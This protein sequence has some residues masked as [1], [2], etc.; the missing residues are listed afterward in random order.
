MV[1]NRGNI[2]ILYGQDIFKAPLYP[3]RCWIPGSV[4]LWWSHETVRA[5]P[6]RRNAGSPSESPQYTGT[7]IGGQGLLPPYCDQARGPTPREST[8]KRLLLLVENYFVIMNRDQSETLP[9]KE[10]FTWTK[11]YVVPQSTDINVMKYILDNH[12]KVLHD[13]Q[14]MLKKYSYVHS[15]AE[16]S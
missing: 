1:H 4:Y 2:L 8:I 5:E 15:Y 10:L 12:M 14:V 13:C 16:N 11:H 9:I 6:V 7:A 3:W